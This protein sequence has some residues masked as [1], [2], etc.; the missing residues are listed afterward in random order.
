M[1]IFNALGSAVYSKLSGGTALTALLNGGTASIY[2]VEPPFEAA[3][4]YVVFN[5]QTGTEPNDTQH[6]IKDV[7]LQ[8]RAYASNLAKAGTIDAACDALL[9]NQGLSISG[10]SQVIM[11]HRMQDVELIEYDESDRPIYTRGGLYDLKIEKQ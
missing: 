7:T 5:L 3:Y 1:S 11:P 8:V 9:H 2:N 6:R 10:W 4:D